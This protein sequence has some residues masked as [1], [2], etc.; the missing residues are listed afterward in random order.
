MFGSLA[1]VVSCIIKPVFSELQITAQE[2]TSS[3]GAYR[4]QQSKQM[5]ETLLGTVSHFEKVIQCKE[6]VTQAC[7]LAVAFSRVQ[8]VDTF[9]IY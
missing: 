8:P 7:Q 3:R 4:V 9:W 2:S 5:Q 6:T 1:I